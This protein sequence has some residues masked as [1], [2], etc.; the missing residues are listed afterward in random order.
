MPPEILTFL[1][2]PDWQPIPLPEG[3][4]LRS[5]RI[6]KGVC[7]VRLGP[8]GDREPASSYH[9]NSPPWSYIPA[10]RGDLLPEVLVDA[11]QATVRFARPTAD[12]G[13]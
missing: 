1:P 10:V 13:S 12:P 9:T 11:G 2:S 3:L 5:Y 4:Q 6:E 7:E 8:A